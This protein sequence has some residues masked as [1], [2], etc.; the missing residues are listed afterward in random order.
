MQSYLYDLVKTNL[1]DFRFKFP[2]ALTKF[3]DADT[4][5]AP[6][7]DEIWRREIQKIM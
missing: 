4:K 6:K 3:R 5:H 1:L 2:R 7:S